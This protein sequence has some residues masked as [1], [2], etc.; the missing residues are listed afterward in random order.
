M[1]EIN[2]PMASSRTL[3]AGIVYLGERSRRRW[4]P[5][6]GLFFAAMVSL[7][8]WSLIVAGVLFLI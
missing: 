1:S 2:L 7:A 3:R 6:V 8:L 4:V 5:A